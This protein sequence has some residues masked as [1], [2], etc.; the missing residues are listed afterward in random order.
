MNIHELSIDLE[1]YSDTDLSRC[2]VYKYAESENFD[3]LL[4][5]VSVNNGPVQVYDL[6][7]GEHMTAR[8][9]AHGSGRP[10]PHADGSDAGRWNRRPP[11]PA[12]TWR[13]TSNR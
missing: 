10:P 12:Q 3:I 2:G 4:F 5:G 11:L 9:G 1:T 8:R 7:S 13:T 6:A